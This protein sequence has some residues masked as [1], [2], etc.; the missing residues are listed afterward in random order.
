MASKRKIKILEVSLENQGHDSRGNCLLIH[1]EVKKL[2]ENTDDTAIQ[3]I[4]D[5][6]E[7]NVIKSCIDR[8]H[9]LRSANEKSLI[10]VKF[11]SYNPRNLVFL[12]KKKL[13]NS[14][15]VITEILNPQKRAYVKRLP[16]LRKKGL[17][18]SN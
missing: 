4:N 1:G 12:N 8:P 3:I 16:K 15:I 17:V 11:L 2:K 18:Y 14:D 10:I 9:R 5:Y 13:K 7:V 6:L